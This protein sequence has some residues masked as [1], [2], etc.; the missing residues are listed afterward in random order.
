MISGILNCSNLCDVNAHC[1]QVDGG[2]KCVCESGYSGDGFSCSCELSIEHWIMYIHVRV[3]LHMFTVSISGE[4]THYG[5]TV[6]P[7]LGSLGLIG[8]L[9]LVA[10]LF[11]IIYCKYKRRDKIGL[12]RDI[13]GNSIQQFVCLQIVSLRV[14]MCVVNRY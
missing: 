8:G 9:L 1:V 5:L 2:V 14:L 4:S 3:T 10:S 7:A 11:A 6:G 12:L 13:N